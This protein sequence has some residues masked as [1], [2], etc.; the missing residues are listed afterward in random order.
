MKR[1]LASIMLVQTA[2]IS[3]GNIAFAEETNITYAD[4]TYISFDSEAYADMSIADIGEAKLRELGYSSQFIDALPITNLTKIAGAKNA[5]QYSSYYTEVIED[6]QTIC[7]VPISEEEFREI[8]QE[9]F[10][11]MSARVASQIQVVDESGNVISPNGT[12][13]VQAAPPGSVTENVDGGTIVINTTFYDIEDTRADG[14]FMVMSEYA[15]VT[16]PSYRGTDFFGSSRDSNI[17][18]LSNTFGNENY[19]IDKKV[20]YYAA[21]SGYVS[22]TLQ[23]STTHYNNNLP[24]EVSSAYAC[25]IELDIPADNPPPPSL[26]VGQGFLAS[27][28][29]NIAGGI[30]YEGRVQSPGTQPQGFN[31]YSTYWHQTSPKLIGSFS[32]SAPL[33]A[34]FTV[35]PQNKFANPVEHVISLNWNNEEFD[36]I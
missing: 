21:A 35:E 33:G 25:V 12:V 19:Y 32:I 20:Y 15:W 9:S 30:W 5:I 18:F 1:K 7:L 28:K 11:E 13:S 8:E 26:V 24:N 16:S 36:I 31:L 23:S 2:F 14:Q 6:G 4:A 34:S 17:Q 29:V 3:F 27:Y 22:E 10:E